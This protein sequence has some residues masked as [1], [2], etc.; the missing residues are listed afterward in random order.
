MKNKFLLPLLLLALSLSGCSDFLDIVPDGVARLE[1]AFNRRAEAKKFLY[2][3]YSFMPK[4]GEISADAAL[5]GDE[6]WTL[7]LLRRLKSLGM[8]LL[9]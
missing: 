6:L 2:T 5:W 1:T 9:I 7:I 3:C 8:K 4:H